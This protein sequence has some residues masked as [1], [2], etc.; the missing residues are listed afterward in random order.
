MKGSGLI[1]LVQRTRD[2]Q[3]IGVIHGH[4]FFFEKDTCDLTKHCAFF[5][6]NVPLCFVFLGHHWQCLNVNGFV[7][8]LQC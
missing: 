5:G 1:L 3:P 8:L 2:D 4:L 7:V 6:L